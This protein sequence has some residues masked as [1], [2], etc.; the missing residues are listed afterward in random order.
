M[1][2]RTAQRQG[3][4]LVLVSLGRGPRGQAT[5]PSLG[6]PTFVPAA[7]TW[8]AGQKAYRTADRRRRGAVARQVAGRRGDQ[9]SAVRMGRARDSR[10]GMARCRIAGAVREAGP[11]RVADERA[12]VL[13]TLK[14]C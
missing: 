14:Q 8:I 2:A 3:A 4:R 11:P 9:Q 13:A 12:H 5:R 10:P 1:N 7:Q 6:G